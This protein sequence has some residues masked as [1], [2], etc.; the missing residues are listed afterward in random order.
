MPPRSPTPYERLERGF[1]R[2]SAQD[3]GSVRNDPPTTLPAF[4]GARPV[5]RQSEV[6]CGAT[7]LYPAKRR[8][9]LREAIP[10]RN[11]MAAW[12]RQAGNSPTADRKWDGGLRR[13]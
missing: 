4:R 9:Q 12:A 5:G 13:G 7:E 2:R 1:G 11:T 3:R 8:E 10:C 6:I